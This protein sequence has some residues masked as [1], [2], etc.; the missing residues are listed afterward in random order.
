MCV[1]VHLCNIVH[2]KFDPNEFNMSELKKML[3]L[4]NFEIMKLSHK[5]FCAFVYFFL[6]HPVKLF[7]V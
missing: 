7:S 5:T 4:E 3:V 1:D 6:T 2:P